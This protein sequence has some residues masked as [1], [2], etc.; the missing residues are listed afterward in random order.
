MAGYLNDRGRRILAALDTV[1][2]EL[3]ASPAQVA[4]AWLIARPNLTSAVA[5]ATS[6]DQLSDL[7]A[8]TALQLTP[9]AIATLDAASAA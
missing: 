7:A 2:S 9:A 3:R 4:I 8:A 5:S 1:A 6:V